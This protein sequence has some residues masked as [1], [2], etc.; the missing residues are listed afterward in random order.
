M[1]RVVIITDTQQTLEDAVDLYL[2][3]MEELVIIVLTAD[4]KHPGSQAETFHT[5]C[6]G[7]YNGPER[8]TM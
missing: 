1:R 8:L 6:E 2:T 7:S 4:L 5:R 3:Q